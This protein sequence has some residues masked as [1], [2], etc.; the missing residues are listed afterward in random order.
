ML[1]DIRFALRTLRQNPGF[2]AIAILSIALAIGANSAIFSLADGLLLRP[3]PVPDA[4]QVVNIRA[5]TPTGNFSNLS[6]ADFLD[7]QSKSRSFDGMFAYNLFSVGLSQNVETQPQLKMG[8]L[9]SG[10]FFQVL[11]VEPQLG[12]RFRPDEDK[13]PGRDAVVVLSHELWKSEFGGDPFVVGRHVRINDVDFS[14]IAVMPE[15]FTGID[16]LFR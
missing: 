5:R 8:Y 14:I 15:S 13:V 1:N 7:F 16:H 2:A 6:Y 4:S 3:L 11:R 10:N 12:R 9:V